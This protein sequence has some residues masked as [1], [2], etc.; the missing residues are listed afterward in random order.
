[1][2]IL[3]DINCSKDV[4]KLTLQQLEILAKEVREK[5]LNTVFK[6]GGHLSSNLGVVDLIIA[7]HYVFDFPQDKFIFDVG[8]QCYAHKILTG[9]KDSFSTLRQKNG[10]S[11]FPKIEESEY[12]CANTGHA[13]TS[14][15]LGCG[16]ARANNYLSQKN[17]V[18]S[19]IGDGAMTG[20]LVFEALNDVFA[21][22]SKQIILLN[23]NEMSIGKNVGYISEYLRSLSEC[24][25]KSKPFCEFGLDYV[26][27]VDGHNF[28]ELI[29]A[30][31]RAKNNKKSII[32]HIA[33]KKGKGFAVA[34]LD[35]CKYHGYSPS[36]CSTKTFSEV[37]GETLLTLATRDKNI[38]AITAAMA[39]GTGLEEF[40]EK[41]PRQFVDVGIAEGH[42]V[43]MSS[44]MALNGIKPYFAVYS[45]FLQRA[46]DNLLHDV[47]LNK[48]PFVI[49]VDRAGFVS[50]DG[51]TH[52]GIYD[53][54]FLS[55]M[56]NMTIFA[57]KDCEELAMALNWSEHFDA[58]LAIRYPKGY[59]KTTYNIH[60]PIEYGKFEALSDNNAQIVLLANGATI[61]DE[62]NDMSIIL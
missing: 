42:A 47:C 57:P 30:F 12:D 32:I 48:L 2:T 43:T 10:I 3:D 5:I 56:P 7:A 51:E 46:F 28:A 6:N 37:F 45:T 29:K 35:P 27:V 9:R 38:F 13:S 11:G 40:E 61:L 33:T 59:A 20:G 15:S 16:F 41:L 22:K 23:D 49:G 25:S 1:M 52:Q 19:L 62:L 24:E 18:I 39:N 21:I 55:C 36:K 44:A 17:N 53:I 50:G 58:P 4:K 60:T 14:I 31:E 26:G 8:H 34:E 54:S